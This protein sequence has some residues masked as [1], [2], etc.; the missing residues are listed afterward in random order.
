MA[1][2]LEGEQLHRQ[3]ILDL[4]LL[5]GEGLS[6][7]ERLRCL[8]SLSN[9]VEDHYHEAVIAKRNGGKRRLLVPDNLLKKVQRQILTQLLEPQPISP[10]AAA[11]HKGA[12]IKA[13]GAAHLGR[14]QVLKLDLK[15]FFSSI[16]FPDVLAAC[17][18]GERFTPAAGVLLTN[19]CC[20][21]GYLPQ[22]APTSP[23]ISNLVLRPFD[24]WVGAWCREQG[25]VYTRYCD[26]LIFSGDFSATAVTGRV[27]NYLEAMGFQLREEKTRCLSAHQQQLV[28]GVVVNEK[29]QVP[30]QYRRAVRQELYYCGKYGVASHLARQGGADGGAEEGVSPEMQRRYLQALLGKIHYILQIDEANLEFQRGRVQVEK[31]L[32]S[33]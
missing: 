17:F 4:P 9:H 10:Y 28:T 20:Y 32:R 25:I 26:D 12:S 31:W 2:I 33:L 22:G 5:Q 30:R 3:E 11:Y 24:T 21:Q 27:R 6:A 8:Y 19:L 1:R 7:A 14:G 15:D 13:N 29:L 16:L 23:A 18:S